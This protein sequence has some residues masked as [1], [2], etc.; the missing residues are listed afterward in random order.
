M[1]ACY[2]PAATIQLFLGRRSGYLCNP[3]K[4]RLCRQRAPWFRRTCPD[5]RLLW[6]TWQ[7]HRF[8]GLPQILRQFQGLGV[9]RDAIDRFLDADLPGGSGSIRDQ[10][11]ADMS[12]EL[13]VA[14][15]QKAGQSD[16]DV[17]RLRER[18]AWRDYD[19]RPEE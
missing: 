1:A 14:L 18:G 16:V 8:D 12:N 6:E 3:M 13:L 5:C 11:A 9:G 15:G 19:R 4:C 7:G 17:K 2:Q 10:M